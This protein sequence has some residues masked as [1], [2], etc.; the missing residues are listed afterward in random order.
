MK[1]SLQFH[2][3]VENSLWQN[4][5]MKARLRHHPA[6]EL[7]IPSNGV[8]KPEEQPRCSPTNGTTWPG[9]TSCSPDQL[10]RTISGTTSQ[11][12]QPVTPPNLR[13]WASPDNTRKQAAPA[14]RC[15]QVARPSRVSHADKRWCFLAEVSLE[16]LEGAI[17]SSNAQPFLIKQGCDY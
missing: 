15:Y 1:P 16:K 7:E 2:P 5:I 8:A 14:H 9:S 17:A 4:P 6:M 12:T 10:W 13:T 11:R 3:A